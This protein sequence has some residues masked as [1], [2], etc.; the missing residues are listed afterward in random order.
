MA[1]SKQI[2]DANP[3]ML[4]ETE[5]KKKKRGKEERGGGGC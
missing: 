5:K 3:R 4:D 1:Q 2:V